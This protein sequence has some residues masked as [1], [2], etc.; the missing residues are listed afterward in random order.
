MT[1]V[2]KWNLTADEVHLSASMININYATK[3]I[4]ALDDIN[5]TV[6]VCS[7]SCVQGRTGTQSRQIQALYSVLS[8][9]KIANIFI[10]CWSHF[11]AK[12]VKHLILLLLLHK[13]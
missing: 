9:R 13:L 7:K 6:C 10:K 3:C 4:V 2:L 8:V 11:K 12:I 1:V 5:H